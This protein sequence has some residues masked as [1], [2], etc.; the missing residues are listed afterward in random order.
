M[1]IGY[2]DCFAGMSSGRF[3]GALANAGVPEQILQ[4]AVDALDIGAR[5]ELVHIKRN[6]IATVKAY[7]SF[8]VSENQFDISQDFKSFF[9]DNQTENHKQILGTIH[10]LISNTYLPSK[11][12]KLILQTF[13]NLAEATAKV[14]GLPIEEISFQEVKALNTIVSVTVCCVACAWLKIDQ[15][16]ISPLNVGSG[17][18]KKSRGFLPIPSPVTLE[19]IGNDALIYASGPQKELLTPTCAALLKALKVN[20]QP[21]P[22]ILISRIGYGAGRMEYD[23]LPNFLRLCIGTTTKDNNTQSAIGEIVIIEAEFTKSS[24]DALIELQTQLYAHGA[25]FVYTVP[26]YSVFNQMSDKVV[27]F[28]LPEQADA[29]RRF[30]FERLKTAYV[31][32]RVEKYEN[33]IHYDENVITPWGKIKVI[34]GQLL[35]NQIVSVVPDKVMCQSI[36]K[37]HDISIIEIEETVKRLFFSGKN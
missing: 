32:W 23:N 31:H 5:L 26:I 16:F 1:R 36:A 34:I 30:L 24:Q 25:K 20:Y 12:K 11:A 19:L 21:C 2:L 17:I 27:I 7:I 8:D 6:N 9:E 15:W 37:A 22:P 10:A 33:L 3:I 35:N 13:Q 28:S 18:K 4:D 14:S 29:M